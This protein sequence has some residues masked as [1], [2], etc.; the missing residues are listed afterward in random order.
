MLVLPAAV[1]GGIAGLEVLQ[2]F[3]VTLLCALPTSLAVVLLVLPA[4]YSAAVKNSPRRTGAPT[5]SVMET[6]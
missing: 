2:R 5:D 1:V 3:G 4:F 6:A